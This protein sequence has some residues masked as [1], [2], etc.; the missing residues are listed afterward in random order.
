MSGPLRLF[1][2]EK[3]EPRPSDLT[4]GTPVDTDSI[5]SPPH[6]PTTRTRPPVNG[7][8][9]LLTISIVID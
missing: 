1:V 5:R 9:H 2:N 6:P 4:V 7:H 3:G 8:L